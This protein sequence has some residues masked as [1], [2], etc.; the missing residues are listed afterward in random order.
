MLAYPNVSRNNRA[1]YHGQGGLTLF[2]PSMIMLL[3]KIG[4]KKL[5]ASAV[6]TAYSQTKR[7]KISFPESQHA[8]LSPQSF[9]CQEKPVR[10]CSGIYKPVCFWQTVFQKPVQ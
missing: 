7:F 10:N 8:A 1:G 5:F 6:N 2:G 9:P 3:I 4:K